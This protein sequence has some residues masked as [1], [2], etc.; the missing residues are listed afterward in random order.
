MAEEHYLT[1]ILGG[2]PAGYP[3]AIRAAQLGQKVAVIER[4]KVGGVCLHRG[5]IPT[6]ALLESAEVYHMASNSKDFGVTADNVSYSYPDI[7][8]RKTKIVDQLQKG[9]EF[10]LNSNNVALIKG[11]GLVT[12]SNSVTVSDG[13][14]TREIKYENLIIA[15]GSRPKSLPGLNID[16][17]HVL[18]SDH[19]L[20]LDHVP[21]SI[22]IVGAGAVGV[23][24][25]SLYN[26][27]GVEVTIVE[28]M[29]TL[30]PL[31]DRDVGQVLARSFVRRGIKVLTGTKTDPESLKIGEGQVQIDI[32]QEEKRETISAEKVLVAVGR[33]AILDSVKDLGLEIERGYIK[34][35]QNMRT[36]KQGVYA[37][38]DAIGGYL[39]AHV[40]TAEGHQA[41][42][43]IAGEKVSP[44]DYNRVPR[45]TYCRPQIGSMG[46]SEQEAKDKGHS[47]KSA[48]YSFQSH[49]RALIAG[50]TEG[51][52]KIV[53]DQETGE[54]LGVHIIGPSATELIAEAALGKY[55]EATPLE[56][57]LSIHAHPTLS[58]AVM[59][60]AL[61][62]EGRPVHMV[63]RR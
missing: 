7:I 43:A 53:S 55:L 34:V 27:L 28:L 1:V 30:V 40:A 58:E 37:V 13:S 19:A 10:L 17:E 59:E 12:T 48:R 2:G 15:T 20:S 8:N 18:S 42:E 11:E 24:F 45:C 21:K 5:C 14:E 3:A 39:L 61:A 25:A 54:I 47:V 60:A 51:F 49:G 63:V 4:D 38:G 56:L 62:V 16:G 50:Q 9:I 57:G 52:V 32:L 31:E 36:N 22:I 6:K 33:E 35:G 41:V 29:P 46:M 23:E 44:I 26:D